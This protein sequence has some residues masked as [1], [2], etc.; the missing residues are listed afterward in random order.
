MKGFP[1]AIAATISLLVT[2]PT[3]AHA[4]DISVTE[5]LAN[6]GIEF[7]GAAACLAFAF[8]N[9]SLP[10]DDY[11]VVAVFV[12]NPNASA[13]STVVPNWVAGT[14]LFDFGAGLEQAFTFQDLNYDL[15]FGLGPGG[16]IAQNGAV[17]SG[18]ISSPFAAFASDPSGDQLSCIGQTNTP[19]CNL[20]DVDTV[21]EPA[22]LMLLGTG[23]F[24]L[25]STVRR[26][27]G[28]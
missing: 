17:A 6:C 28:K 22:S 24:G 26:K 16:E 10:A 21:P 27:L 23:L 4:D 15:S 13:A 18:G 25:A 7:Q 5:T 8:V 9:G 1:L 20:S 19:G 14:G 2:V 11:T 12:G 3:L